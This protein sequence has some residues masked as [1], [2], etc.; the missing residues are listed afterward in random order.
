MSQASQ[1]EKG[2]RRSKR[3]QSQAAADT[4]PVTATA[5]QA[6]LKEGHDSSG[7][8]TDNGGGDASDV[9]EQ[10][11]VSPEA[12]A[13]LE[14]ASRGLNAVVAALMPKKKKGKKSRRK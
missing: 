12:M 13:G 14:A 7:T 1:K 5:A 9:E 11:T 6:T 10:L 4:T 3:I 8:D 2:W